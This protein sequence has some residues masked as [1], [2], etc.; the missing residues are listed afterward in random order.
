VLCVFIRWPRLESMVAAFL[1][2][3]GLQSLCLLPSSNVYSQSLAQLQV[4]KAARL[5]V[6]SFI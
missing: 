1:S 4:V 3:L 6:F 2:S 5:G